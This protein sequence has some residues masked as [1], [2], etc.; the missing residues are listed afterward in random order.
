MDNN[1]WQKIERLFYLAQDEG[2]STRRQFLTGACEGDQQLLKEVESL[3]QFSERE[4]PIFE[5]PLFAK[6]PLCDVTASR[7]VPSSGLLTVL[8]SPNPRL[9]LSDCYA[10]LQCSFDK[11]FL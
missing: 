9:T 4:I 5:E 11:S 8:E 1:S 6:P 7:C 10:T 3:L 2:P